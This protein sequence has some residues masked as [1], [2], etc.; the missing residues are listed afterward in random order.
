MIRRALVFAIAGALTLTLSTLDAR[1]VSIPGTVN[2]TIRIIG[3]LGGLVLGPN[4]D[5]I[6]VFHQNDDDSRG[7]VEFNI[8]SLTA[9]VSS[10]HI[11]LTRQDSGPFPTRTLN[12]LG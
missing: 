10:A 12:A 2:G 11:L 7:I 9:P 1:A 4:P 5:Y 6:E 3:S 8:S